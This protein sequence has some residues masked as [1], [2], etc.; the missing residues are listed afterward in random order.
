MRETRQLLDDIGRR[1]GRRIELGVWVEKD[2]EVN[3]EYAQDVIAWMKADLIDSVTT[4]NGL[5][6]ALLAAAQ[7]YR[8]KHILS[9]WPNQP[10]EQFVEETLQGLDA[11]VDGLAIWDLDQFQDSPE[12]WRIVHGMGQRR[13]VAALR[14]ERWRSPS[15]RLKTL[16]GYDVLAGLTP[17]VYSGG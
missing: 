7:A 15:I 8:R 11:E 12:W 13:Q 6:H 17:A 4:L 10:R 14:G 2:H 3:L 9:V 5:S 16:A 1:Q